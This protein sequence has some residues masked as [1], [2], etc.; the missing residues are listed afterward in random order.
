MLAIL[1]SAPT[2]ESFTHCI[3]CQ[4]MLVLLSIR[5]SRGDALRKARPFKR[6]NSSFAGQHRECAAEVRRLFT[7]GCRWIVLHVSRDSLSF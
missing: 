6:Q 2:V 7:L 5:S 1:R 4:V 3:P